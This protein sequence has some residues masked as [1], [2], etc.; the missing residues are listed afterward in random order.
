MEQN[1]LQIGRIAIIVVCLITIIGCRQ[2]PSDKLFSPIGN[3]IL[4][5]L[6]VEYAAQMQEIDSTMVD[7]PILV[8]ELEP[9]DAE[10]RHNRCRISYIA[11]MSDFMWPR[12]V[13]RVSRIGNEENDIIVGI[14]DQYPS[15]FRPYV[16]KRTISK[17]FKYYYPDAY[18]LYR[19]YANK[20]GFGDIPPNGVIIDLPTWTV[21]GDSV[22]WE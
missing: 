13:N 4:E 3:D 14:V 17:I 18:K 6:I 22:Y 11:G 16:R 5:K 12:W 9:I 10:I 21:T 7:F 20:H 2:R 19:R 8:R 15:T 1:K